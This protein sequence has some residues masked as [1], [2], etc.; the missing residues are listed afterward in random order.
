M[1]SKYAAIN[2]TN[3]SQHNIKVD[4]IFIDDCNLIPEIETLLALQIPSKSSKLKRLALFAHKMSGRPHSFDDTLV[5]AG[6]TL[7]LFHRLMSSGFSKCFNLDP[8]DQISSP[9][10]SFVDS[11][12]DISAQSNVF[13]NSL[14][15]VNVSNVLGKGE[16]AP[17]RN[18][19][20]N[21]DEAE[22]AVAL[23]QLLRLNNVACADIAIISAYKGQVDLI[24]EVLRSRCDWTDFYGE[25]AFVGT[26]DQTNSLHFK[27]KFKYTVSDFRY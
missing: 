26:I 21:L 6:G 5:A 9:W 23:Y 19:I 2:C 17:M 18:Y 22:Y 7:S 20:Q 13:K 14:Q 15:F 1:T 25:P 16:E 12:F 24:K 8:S 11:K 10:N 27:R 3:L 4:N